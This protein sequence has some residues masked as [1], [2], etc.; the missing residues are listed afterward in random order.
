MQISRAAIQVYE[1]GLA[2][3][4][5][6]DTAMKE[7]FGTP[8]GSMELSDFVGLDVSIGTMSTLERELGS[9]YEVPE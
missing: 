1:Q 6:I 2:S 8:M 9:C 4:D 7:Q 3:A 5:E